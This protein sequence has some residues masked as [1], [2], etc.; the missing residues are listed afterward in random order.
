M[1]CSGD[2]PTR[3]IRSPERFARIAGD[4]TS[5]GSSASQN[6][7]ARAGL[8]LAG[9]DI[10]STARSSNARTRCRSSACRPPARPSGASSYDPRISARSPRFSPRNA[11]VVAPP[12]GAPCRRNMRTGASLARSG[13]TSGSPSSDCTG[14]SLGMRRAA[15][16]SAS[17]PSGES[18]A[19]RSHPPTRR[20]TSRSAALS[21]RPGDIILPRSMR[22]TCSQR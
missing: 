18:G 6:A 22:S 7:S 5:S 4:G 20:M 10:T 13:C 19:T 8:P 9:L 1:A 11:M 21:N 2:A 12:E 16:S 3:K 14:S 17:R 15:S